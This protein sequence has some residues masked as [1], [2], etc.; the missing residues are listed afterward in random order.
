MDIRAELTLRIA[1]LVHQQVDP[2]RSPAH[3][4]LLFETQRAT[5]PQALTW[6][7]QAPKP[8]LVTPLIAPGCLG[9]WSLSRLDET[10]QA[11]FRY[12]MDNQVNGFEEM[13]RHHGLTAEDHIRFEPSTPPLELS[14]GEFLQWA[15]E[16]ALHVGLAIMK[17]PNERMGR[18]IVMPPS[19]NAPP[20]GCE[21]THWP[22][23]S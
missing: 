19:G 15:R 7:A 21:P 14:V 13:L 2:P 1:L 12:E 23:A 17:V 16:Y 9:V 4:S 10:R 20:L 18:L 22:P 5:W 8:L 3:W 6:L 11:R